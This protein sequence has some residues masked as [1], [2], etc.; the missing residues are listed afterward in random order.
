MYN[1]SDGPRSFDKISRVLRAM[2][3]Y[4]LIVLQY[5][6]T[7]ALNDVVQVAG[8]ATGAAEKYSNS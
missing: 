5:L 7:S 3:V 4:T 1:Y 2:H 8:Q 6:R